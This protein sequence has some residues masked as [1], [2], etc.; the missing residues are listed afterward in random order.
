MN[1]KTCDREFIDDGDQQGFCGD[2]LAE[3]VAHAEREAELDALHDALVARDALIIARDAA[4]AA[5]ERAVEPCGICTEPWADHDGAER[6]CPYSKE[7]RILNG[8][9]RY[10]AKST[11]EVTLVADKLERENRELERQRDA[12]LASL[13]KI[14]HCAE[15]DFPLLPKRVD[16][17]N[18]TERA[19]ADIVSQA[20]GGLQYIGQE[21]VPPSP[22]YGRCNH[23]RRSTTGGGDGAVAERSPRRLG[24]R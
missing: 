11:W 18:E 3:Q 1:C 15:Q 4:Y 16:V 13:E 17:M 22:Q 19:I 10:C 21:A 24:Q 2:C 7:D 12:L 23:E 9:T 8:E 5:L 14:E 20:V 6:Y